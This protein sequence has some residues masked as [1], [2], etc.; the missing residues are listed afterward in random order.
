MTSARVT[1]SSR[2]ARRR[3]FTVVELLVTLGVISLLIALVLPAVQSA[4]ESA[5]RTQCANNLHQIGIALENFLALH[6]RLPPDL[7]RTGN[8]LGQLLSE[9]NVPVQV[10][11]LPYLDQ[12]ALY[13]RFDR[14]DFGHGIRNDPPTTSVNDELL[15]MSVAVYLCPSDATAEPRCNYRISDGPS[16]SMFSVI[17]AGLSD[18]QLLGYRS[19]FGRR[20]A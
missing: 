18:H 14:T 7:R 9:Y 4:R 12:K 10:E 1:A 5:R 20:D 13:D 17:L 11:L 15:A 19:L 6:A 16:P 2:D 3:G 8:G